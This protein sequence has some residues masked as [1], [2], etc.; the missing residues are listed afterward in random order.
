[1]IPLPPKDKKFLEDPK[2][3]PQLTPRPELYLEA[4]DKNSQILAWAELAGMFVFIAINHISLF[5]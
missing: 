2:K 3:S 4:P 5:L 1:M